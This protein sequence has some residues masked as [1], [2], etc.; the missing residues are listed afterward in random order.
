MNVILMEGYLIYKKS[1]DIQIS[2]PQPPPPQPPTTGSSNA[3]P[4]L[5]GTLGFASRK[6]SDQNE[7]MKTNSKMKSTS[8]MKMTSKMKTTS[9]L[10]MNS[11]MKT[12]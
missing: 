3:S 9:N 6:Y 12:S 10:K 5:F 4:F 2:T 8:K 7:N 1:P 11:E